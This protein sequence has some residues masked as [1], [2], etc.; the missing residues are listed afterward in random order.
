MPYIYGQMRGIC[1]SES[2]NRI[3]LGLLHAIE[4]IW[5]IYFVSLLIDGVDWKT[6][7]STQFTNWATNIKM[8]NENNNGKFCFMTK[9]HLV[10]KLDVIF[11][12]LIYYF[13][14]ILYSNKKIRCYS[15]HSAM[16]IW[17][18]FSSNDWQVCECDFDNRTISKLTV[19]FE[20]TT[21]RTQ[22]DF[23]CPATCQ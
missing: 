16:M 19:C 1:F 17:T 15:M 9:I 11:R 22:S 8:N 4:F 20:L 18:N 7:C 12:S 23:H 13:A 5:I 14:V 2:N 3:V 6:I 21:S 10:G